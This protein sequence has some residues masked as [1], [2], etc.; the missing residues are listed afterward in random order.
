MKDASPRQVLELVVPVLLDDEAILR[1][2]KAPY[3]DDV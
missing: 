1:E 2:T 3:P